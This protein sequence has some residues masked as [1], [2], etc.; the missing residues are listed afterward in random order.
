MDDAKAI[1][2]SLE[3]ISTKGVSEELMNR[4]EIVKDKMEGFEHKPV[5]LEHVLDGRKLKSFDQ[6]GLLKHV[7]KTIIDSYSSSKSPED[8]LQQ[9]F[10]DFTNANYVNHRMNGVPYSGK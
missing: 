8:I 6:K 3:K 1:L 7:A 9:I 10:A 4:L 5:L 2:E